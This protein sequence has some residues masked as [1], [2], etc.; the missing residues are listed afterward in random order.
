MPD[1]LDYTLRIEP[2]TPEEWLGP[3]PVGAAFPQPS[4]PLVVDL[5]C[6]KGRFL[7][8]HA[9]RYPDVNHLGIDRMLRRIRKVDNRARRLALDNIRLMRIEAYY[10]VAY[11]LPTAAVSTYYIFFPDPWPKARHE[12]HRLFNPIFLDA[13]QRTL[14]EGGVVH[15]ATD[16]APYFE[17]LSAIF[18]ADARFAPVP[19]YVPPED[20]QTDF[21]RYYIG[22]KPIGRLSVRRV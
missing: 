2:Q 3:V 21:E 14:I 6:G 12:D 19:P 5:G 22:Q 1:M 9:A 11:L 17:Q 4:Q 7:L 8:A 16:H 13:L 15:V 20:E 18:A 10:T